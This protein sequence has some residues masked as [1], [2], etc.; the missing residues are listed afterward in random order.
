MNEKIIKMFEN[1]QMQIDALNERVSTLETE[2]ENLKF[3]LD[4][5]DDRTRGF[6]RIGRP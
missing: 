1:M 2:N 3:E 6:Q 5:V 4:D